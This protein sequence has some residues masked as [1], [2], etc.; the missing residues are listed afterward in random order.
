MPQIA[1]SS[2][3]AV[4][5]VAFGSLSAQPE[6]FKDSDAAFNVGAAVGATSLL[7]AGSVAIAMGGCVI[8]SSKCKRDLQSGLF[9]EG[10][11]AS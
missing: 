9:L 6:R 4:T 11:D 10:G 2:R 3:F 7:P 1:P 5:H 8:D